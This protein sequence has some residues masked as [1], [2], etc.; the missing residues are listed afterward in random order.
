M[1]KGKNYNSN[2]TS[3]ELCDIFRNWL[4]EKYSNAKFSVTKTTH[5]A[6]NVSLTEADFLPFTDSNTKYKQISQF[7]IKDSTELTET[8]KK[9]LT[10]VVDLIESYNFDDSDI[11]TDYFHVNFYLHLSIGKWDKPFQHKPKLNNFA[12]T[13][14]TKPQ[15]ADIKIINYSEKAIVVTGNTYEIRDKLKSMGGKFNRFLKCGAGWVFKTEQ[16]ANLEKLII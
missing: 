5:L 13:T 9:M 3:K 14:I 7:H 1:K 8:A 2:L 16:K 15:S 12:T 4:K 6:I 10:E 11:M